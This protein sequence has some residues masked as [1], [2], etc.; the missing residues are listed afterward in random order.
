MKPATD[1][2]FHP[3]QEGASRLRHANKVE[4]QEKR[5]KK[6]AQTVLRAGARS[7]LRLQTLQILSLCLMPADSPENEF[8]DNLVQKTDDE[9][10]NIVRAR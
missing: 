10:F 5:N 3:L 9:L 1:L 2:V 6:S 8:Q 7:A 4:E